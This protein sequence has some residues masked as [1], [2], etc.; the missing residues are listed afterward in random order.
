M[1]LNEGSYLKKLEGNDPEKKE[2]AK[3]LKYMAKTAIPFAYTITDAAEM[4]GQHTS[5][6]VLKWIHNMTQSTVVP[7]L[8]T[9]VAK[10]TDKPGT[11]PSNLGQKPTYRKP[12]DTAEAIKLGIP[13]L[14]Q[15]VPPYAPKK[16]SHQSH[17]MTPI[18][19]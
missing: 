10:A 6:S 2:G 14:R 1:V 13:G 7:Q 5:E 3:E 8:V 16:P 12:K 11:F 9:Q 15:T 19:R 17:G 4:L 18:R